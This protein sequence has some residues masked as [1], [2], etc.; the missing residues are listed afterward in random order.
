MKRLLIEGAELCNQDSNSVH[1]LMMYVDTNLSTLYREL[2][3]ENFNRI[4]EIVWEQL[5]SILDE[6]IQSNLDKRRPP[7]FFDNLNKTLSLMLGSFK[8]SNDCSNCDS[9]KRTEQILRI[10]GLETADL[11][12]YVHKNLAKEFSEMKDSPYGEISIRAK[13]ES[14]TL[15]IEIMNAR[16]LMAMDSNGACDSFVRVHLLPEHKF[17]GIDKPKTKTHNKTQFPLYD[18]IFT[19][20]FFLFPLELT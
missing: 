1:R 15:T 5:S 11:I 12:H 9:L 7:S 20:Y 2:N 16:N 3:E 19:M 17:S 13:I 6:I 10:N 18:E 14:N 8:R 4:L